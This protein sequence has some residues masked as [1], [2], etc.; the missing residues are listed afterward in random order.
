[1]SVH[2]EKEAAGSLVLE[3]CSSYK[4]VSPLAE[5]LLCAKE[6]NSTDTIG[7]TAMKVAWPIKRQSEKKV[8]SLVIWLKTPAAAGHLFQ[9]R[10]ARFGEHPEHSAQGLSQGRASTST[11]TAAHTGTNKRTALRETIPSV[12]YVKRNTLCSTG[13]AAKHIPEKPKFGPA[14]PPAMAKEKLAEERRA[15]E[16]AIEQRRKKRGEA[17]EYMADA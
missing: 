8:G 4:V 17:G 6:Q 14:L 10:L 16:R 2:K 9:Q 12:Q 11:I 5:P 13:G 15:K 3:P 7:C 1:M